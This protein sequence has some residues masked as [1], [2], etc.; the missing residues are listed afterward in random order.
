MNALLRASL[1]L[2]VWYECLVKSWPPP[3]L[4]SQ[5]P[6]Q[7]WGLYSLPI[8]V[9]MGFSDDGWEQCLSVDVNIDIQKVAGCLVDLAQQQW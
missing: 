1:H 4:Y 5:H 2:R 7:P 6:V 9:K 8:S 3:I